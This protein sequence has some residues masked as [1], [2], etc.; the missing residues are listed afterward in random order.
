MID[1]I[2][3]RYVDG[4]LNRKLSYIIPIEVQSYI[5]TT[6]YKKIT[7]LYQA[8]FEVFSSLLLPT[9]ESSRYCLN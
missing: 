9:D 4:E 1:E 8:K 6:S 5:L 2:S 7:G 3:Y